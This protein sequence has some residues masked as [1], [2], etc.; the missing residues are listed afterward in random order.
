MRANLR[1]LFHD[2]DIQLA[3]RFRRQLQKPA[4]RTEAARAGADDDHVKVH[5]F[6]FCHGDSLMLSNGLS[7]G[8][9]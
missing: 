9:F 2:A 4:G 3:T 6:S 1:T 7:I 5:G 8:E